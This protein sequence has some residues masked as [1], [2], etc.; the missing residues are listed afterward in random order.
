M[1]KALLNGVKFFDTD[2]D[3]DIYALTTA[4]VKQTAGSA[5]EF[6]FT[7]PPQNSNYG[8]I[9]RLVDYV[10]VYDGDDIIFAGR[11][12]S[13][14]MLFD[15]QYRISCEGL[16]AV[17]GDSIFRPRTF[18]GRLHDLI[19]AIITEHNSQVSTD[20][21]LNI[22]EITVP[23]YTINDREFRNYDSSISRI[24]E[25]VETYGGSVYVRKVS[26][27][28]YF[29]WI[30]T[31]NGYSTQTIKLGEN[32]LD[33]S[34]KHDSS[35]VITVLIPTGAQQP[36]GSKLTISSANGGLDYI[37]ARQDLIDEY[38]LIY[39]TNDWNDITSPQ[40]LKDRAQDWL[41][42][43]TQPNYSVKIKA[44]DLKNAGYDVTEF[45]V[46]QLIQ[47]ISVPHGMVDTMTEDSSTVDLGIVDEAIVDVGG[48]AYWFEAKEL[49]LNLL[50]VSQSVLQL[51]DDVPGYVSTEGRAV[52]AV[53][54]MLE[55]L[56]RAYATL[57]V[58][59]DSVARATDLI[60]GNLGGYIVI[61]DSNGDGYPDE[62]LIMD[63]PDVETAVRVWRWNKNGL[64]YSS[65]GYNGEYET[66]ITA[67]GRIVAD[68]ITAGT[69][70]GDRV[71]TGLLVSEDGESYWNL[72]TGEFKTVGGIFADGAI[73]CNGIFVVDAAGNVTATAITAMGQI[74]SDDGIIGGWHLHDGYMSYTMGGVNI[75]LYGGSHVDGTSVSQI[76]ES[77][78]NQYWST[79]TYTPVMAFSQNGRLTTDGDLIVH[80][81]YLEGKIH[82]EADSNVA[83]LSYTVVS[84]F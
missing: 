46:G 39:G 26:N 69:L 70:S 3:L 84:T 50:D 77:Q 79:P 75:F 59:D 37:T 16:L 14:E 52:S 67:D 44:V 63:T 82:T 23:N 27:Q 22:G 4:L 40:E 9:H 11:V 56:N 66:A 24:K 43:L 62:I 41:N 19:A 49:T 34:K 32:L 7:I 21:Y 18:S 45:K 51:G 8:N 73:N 54:S 83:G 28:L 48:I 20:K 29:D 55:T 53:V 15:T 42:I 35:S 38:G 61:R 25:L 31:A 47:V 74:K 30:R 5:G 81:I 10:D 57:S 80:D 71:R 17:L 76:F 2:S 78:A 1:Y 12:F 36:D 58:M 65:T 33:F 60:T 13:I 64:G 68:F 72:D 6:T